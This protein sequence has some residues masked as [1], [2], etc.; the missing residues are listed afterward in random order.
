MRS[1]IQQQTFQAQKRERAFTLIELLVVIAIIAILASLLLPALAKAKERTKR[2]SCLNNLKQLGVGSVMYATDF[3]GALT[4]CTS[5]ADDSM[6]WIYPAYVSGT[7]SYTCPSSLN[8]VRPDVYS[9][10]AGG[11]PVLRDLADIAPTRM[12]QWGHSYEQ[13]SWW[14]DYSTGTGTRKTETL[15]QT[16]KHK[17]NAFGL[18]DQVIGPVNSWLM[19][20][21]DDE[22]DPGPPNNYNDYPDAINNHGV[23]GA[24]VNFADGHA[25]WV[26][27]KRYV[28]SYELSADQGR[29]G[30]F[31][32][33]NP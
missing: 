13:F 7:K 15:V 2:I 16:R 27:T 19:V 32:T 26:P 8:T 6:Y 33:H 28:F 20:D 9:P 5:Y 24:N 10:G 12:T 22:V 18:K 29:I 21:A 1:V 30:I 17:F 4:G 11:K 23:E 25:T 31:P 14:Y 3:N